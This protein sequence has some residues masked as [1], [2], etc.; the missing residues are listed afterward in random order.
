M[1]FIAYVF[2]LVYTVETT[3]RF[4]IVGTI[5]SL[6]PNATTSFLQKVFQTNDTEETSMI[7][8]DLSH[9]R[10]NRVFANARLQH[11]IPTAMKGC[12]KKEQGKLTKR[13]E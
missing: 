13:K 11:V 2:T 7:Y 5:I 6:L 9:K 12:D 8:D 1:I 10:G 4:I 3:R